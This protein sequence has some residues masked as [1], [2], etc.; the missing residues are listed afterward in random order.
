MRATADIFAFSS[1]TVSEIAATTFNHAF[2]L[3]DSLHVG[4]RGAEWQEAQCIMLRR[5]AFFACD[6]LQLGRHRRRQRGAS[7]AVN[8]FCRASER[9]I[10]GGVCLG[11]ESDLVCDQ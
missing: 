11:R 8:G 9:M 3:L 10:D 7:K 6:R 4:R 2:V 1:S 5:D